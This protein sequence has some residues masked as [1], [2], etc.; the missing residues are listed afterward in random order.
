M[1]DKTSPSKV[2]PESVPAQIAL[3]PALTAWL[4]VDVSRDRMPA[5]GSACNWSTRMWSAAITTLRE[6]CKYKKKEISKMK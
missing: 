5:K 4:F 3:L 1:D 6:W 2:A